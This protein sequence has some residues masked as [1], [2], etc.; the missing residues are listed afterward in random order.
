MKFRISE[1]LKEAD[2]IFFELFRFVNL[3][4]HVNPVNVDEEKELF[5]SGKK[6]NP[7]F[8]YKPPRRDLNEIRFRY[9]LSFGGRVLPLWHHN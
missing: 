7:F 9:T 6:R 5:L 8:K 1:E 2:R 3:I 4:R